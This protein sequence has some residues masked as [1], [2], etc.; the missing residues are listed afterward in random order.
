M[1]FAL[2]ALLIPAMAVGDSGHVVYAKA[3]IVTDL[4]DTDGDGLADVT[5]SQLKTDPENPDT[6]GDGLTDGDE[7]ILLGTSALLAD[8]DGDGF[9]D[10]LEIAAGA[11]PFAVTSFPVTVAGFV[12]NAVPWMSGKIY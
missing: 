6:D 4:A 3:K 2:V 5:E 10:G 7:E 11:D 8:G 12:T 9:G 1:I